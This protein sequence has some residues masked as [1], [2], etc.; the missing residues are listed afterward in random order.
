[1]T[2]NQIILRVNSIMSVNAGVNIEDI[3]PDDYPD[4]LGAESIKCIESLLEIED[5][6]DIKI[7]PGETSGITT[8]QDVY[9]LVERKINE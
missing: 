2:K 4:E 7:T 8:M 3:K 9:D 5:E 1:M 6:F